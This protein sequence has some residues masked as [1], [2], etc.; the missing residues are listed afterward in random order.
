MSWVEL[1]SVKILEEYILL[2]F[3]SCPTL[4]SFSGLILSLIIVLF[5]VLFQ[6]LDF[7][8]VFL[9]IYCSDSAPF[10]GAA[11]KCH[12]TLAISPVRSLL[13]P[14]HV[15]TW[16]FLSYLFLP[17]QSQRRERNFSPKFS[18]PLHSSSI[19]LQL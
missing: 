4:C 7:L 3:Y 13:A 8:T 9:F 1:L 5:P 18:L 14:F 15:Q 16:M 17:S 10:R 2:F 11:L 12:Q 6:L 19:F